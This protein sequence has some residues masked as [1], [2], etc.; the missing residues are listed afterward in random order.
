MGKLHLLIRHIY[1]M[2]SNQLFK[3]LLNEY[4]F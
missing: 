1:Y 3:E 2:S 4:K